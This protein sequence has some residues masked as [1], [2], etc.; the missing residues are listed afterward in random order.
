M[1]RMVLLVG[2]TGTGKTSIINNYL[3]KLPREKFLI[4]NLSFSAR[5]SSNQIQDTIMAK[6]NR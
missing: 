5:T 4:Y 1:K 2:P 3:N 6:M